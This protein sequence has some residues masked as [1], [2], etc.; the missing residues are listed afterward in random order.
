MGETRE[1][2]KLKGISTAD[3]EDL[4]PVDWERAPRSN[5]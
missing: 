4:L 5:D 2:S 3:L 1:A